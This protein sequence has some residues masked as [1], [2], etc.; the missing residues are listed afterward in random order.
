MTLGLTRPLTEMNTKDFP[1]DAKARPANKES[2]VS[3]FV[4][5][6]TSHNRIGLHG[7][8]QMYLYIFIPFYFTY[9]L[10]VL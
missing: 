6:S 9:G 2:S 7:M 5:S 8:L 4:A 3:L 1:G 10:K